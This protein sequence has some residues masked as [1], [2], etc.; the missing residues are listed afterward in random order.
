MQ[1]YAEER[2]HNEKE[3]YGKNTFKLINSIGSGQTDTN[4]QKTTSNHQLPPVRGMGAKK[5]ESFYY[6]ALSVSSLSSNCKGLDCS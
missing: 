4:C 1:E 6:G 5:P 3:N 2:Q